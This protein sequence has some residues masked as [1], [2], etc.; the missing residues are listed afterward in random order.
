MD[1]V[2][3]LPG[4]PLPKR[5]TKKRDLR[6]AFVGE[7]YSNDIK[8]IVHLRI[9]FFGY[10]STRRRNDALLLLTIHILFGP[11]SPC[12][13]A[14][15]HFDKRRRVA[16]LCN[17]V[18]LEA[19]DMSIALEYRVSVSLKIPCRQ[20]L[21]T[22]PYRFG[23]KKTKHVAPS[24]K[25]LD[26]HPGV[27]CPKITLRFAPVA[28]GTFAGVPQIVSFPNIANAIASRASTGKLY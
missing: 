10:I 8:A 21:S 6:S 17:D 18:Y 12:A 22:F 16:F 19:A 23:S 9:V 3:D 13:R 4:R 11:Y 26:Y 5:I 28:L 20:G 7:Y 2:A 27:I 15:L 14:C 25:K 24:V 1:F